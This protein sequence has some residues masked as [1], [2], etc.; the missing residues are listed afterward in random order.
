MIIRIILT[1]LL[2]YGVYIETGIWTALTIFL[3]AV[4]GELR[5]RFFKN[6]DCRAYKK[7]L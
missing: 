1:L 2:I 5:D 6:S 7:E 4:S 3:I